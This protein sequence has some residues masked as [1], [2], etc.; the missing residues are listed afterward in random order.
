MEFFNKISKWINVCFFLL[1]A[2]LWYAS[3]IMV[4][5]KFKQLIHKENPYVL[6]LT[7]I[8]FTIA[9]LISCPLVLLCKPHK[10]T[11]TTQSSKQMKGYIVIG[12][13][14][15][16][17]QVCTNTAL[18]IVSVTLT[19]VI[20]ITEPI[21]A[22][23]LGISILKYN[24]SKTSLSYICFI[25][26]GIVLTN[27]SDETL[28]FKGVIF[29]FLSN[30]AF[31]VR[32]LFILKHQQNND[33]R[34]LYI[35]FISCV[36]GLGL[37]SIL[38]L[39]HNA[40]KGLSLTLI[41]DTVNIQS[42]MLGV[43]FAGQH[44]T[45]YIVLDNV[46]IIN[47]ALLNAVKRTV[48]IGASELM[49]GP[50]IK[51]KQY[52]GVG[53]VIVGG[54]FYTIAT[55]EENSVQNITCDINEYKT[56]FKESMGRYFWTLFNR[57]NVTLYSICLIVLCI[58]FS[59]YQVIR[60][61][62]VENTITAIWVYNEPLSMSTI[63]YL[64]YLSESNSINV[65]CGGSKCMESLKNI[66]NIEIE[67]L[68]AFDLCAGT[69][70]HP[71]IRRHPI[72]KIL[73]G[74][75][76]LMILQKAMTLAALWNHGGTVIDLDL[77]IIH[78]EAFMLYLRTT[79]RGA[80]CMITSINMPFGWCHLEKK[81]VLTQ[82]I[83]SNFVELY[84]IMPSKFKFTDVV[85]KTLQSD[86]GKQHLYLDISKDIDNMVDKM[87][88][89]T[90]DKLFGIISF[91]NT[92]SGNLGDD[93]QS[94]ASA[95]ILPNIDVFMDRRT[96][97]NVKRDNIT[98][99]ANA[100]WFSNDFMFHFIPNIN[101]VPAAVH[102]HQVLNK[103]HMD[104]FMFNMNNKTVGSRDIATFKI[105]EKYRIPSIFTGCLTLF[106][107]NPFKEKER[108][109]NIYIVDVYWNLNVKTL[110]PNN[111]T[112]VTLLSHSSKI[113]HNEQVTKR[114]IQA[115]DILQKYAQ[116]KVVITSRIHVALPCVALGTPVIFINTD[117]IYGA[118]KTHPSPRVT[119]L[120]DI[121]HTVDLYKVTQDAA[122]K[123]LHE[124]NWDEPPPNPNCTMVQSLTQAA[125]TIMEEVE[126][127]RN[128][129]NIYKLR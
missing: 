76:Y 4:N 19:H 116:A 48:I 120:L 30:I 67:Q 51:Y 54:F 90:Q 28:Q 21:I 7:L 96:F 27:T 108:T 82:S 109:N 129:R 107:Q 111:N 46:S 2:I 59:G 94:L 40:Y 56:T 74:S 43:Y 15:A 79:T 38:T 50:H 11:I 8:Q 16:I 25:L 86:I 87:S 121:F 18:S 128:T 44:I 31:P 60:D 3:S 92:L 119:G 115:Y 6:H 14:F 106:I 80:C 63:T 84:N 123:F 102:L 29:A 89:H 72:N 101:P 12:V 95:H 65:Y 58:I 24:I 124:F 55:H 114:Y 41:L 45:S 13:A 39:A 78:V 64:K 36:T 83:I 53:M 103:I 88:V 20:K 52:V 32:N 49:L 17:G 69:E 118:S 77:N 93:I 75:H 73:S 110:I 98:F 9:T 1:I 62:P 42:M 47:H 105:L 91:N 22:M 81:H 37:L 125:W 70:L 61:R 122:R 113:D 68:T 112:N 26:A 10:E 57:R 127:F 126:E 34:K 104:K 117:A 33:T 35:Y 85:K 100:F 23:L 99:I 71:W 97:R 66:S 5:V